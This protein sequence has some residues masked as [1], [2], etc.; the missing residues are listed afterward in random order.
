MVDVG[1]FFNKLKSK[2]KKCDNEYKVLR[3]Q[4]GKMLKVYRGGELNCRNGIFFSTDL[5]TA[6]D[7]G[8]DK[9]K[10][11]ANV[12]VKKPLIID[13]KKNNYEYI[14]YDG[15]L[16]S[17]MNNLKDKFYLFRNELYLNNNY[18]NL[19][20]DEYVRFA[21]QEKYDAL[22]ILNVCEGNNIGC[23]NKIT[24]DIVVWNR[25]NLFNVRKITDDEPQITNTIDVSELI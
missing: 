20:T 4:D 16:N 18:N 8:I 10:Y 6:R 22:I 5:E 7:F 14:S 2:I 11:E 21:I 17:E 13:A 12:K 9:I 15:C 23:E 3:D 25:E 19:S 1:K 24:T